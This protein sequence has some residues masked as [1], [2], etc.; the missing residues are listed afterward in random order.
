VLDVRHPMAET[1]APR[2][3][4][5]ASPAEAPRAAA[6]A[7]KEALEATK[8]MEAQHGKAAAFG[9]K[10]KGIQ[11]AGGTVACILIEETSAAFGA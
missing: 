2:P 1:L 6:Q 5:G 8:E 11:D 9:E 7:A 10:S 4:A 3:Q